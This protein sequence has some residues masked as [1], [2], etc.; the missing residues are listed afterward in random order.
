MG[1]K[2]YKRRCKAR[3]DPEKKKTAKE[4]LKKDIDLDTVMKITGLDRKQIE[5]LLATAH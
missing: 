5:K 3:R 1:K 2:C 4:M